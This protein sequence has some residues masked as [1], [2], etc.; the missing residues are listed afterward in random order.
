MEREKYKAACK[1][2]TVGQDRGILW[3]ANQERRE[4]RVPYNYNEHK[5]TGNTALFSP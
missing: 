5:P 1:Q 3:G 4:L 2:G